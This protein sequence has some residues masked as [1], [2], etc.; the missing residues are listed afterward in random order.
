M[1]P[2][3][4]LLPLSLSAWAKDELKQADL[5]KLSDPSQ[6]EA[7]VARIAECDG[8]ERILT[9]FQFHPLPQTNGEPLHLL[10]VAYEFNFDHLRPAIR[11]Y[12]V[13]DPEELFGK[14]P[15][16]LVHT[17]LAPDLDLITDSG[18]FV[19]DAEGKEVRPFGGNNYISEG[20][21]YDF[22]KDGV[23]ERADSMNYSVKEAPKTTIQVFELESFELDSQVK[24]RVLFNWHPRSDDKANNWTFQC[25]DKDGDGLVEIGFGPSNNPDHHPFIFRWNPE[26]RY[27]SAGEIP[28]DAHIRILEPDEKLSDIAKAGGHSYPLI[29]E[30]EEKN[31]QPAAKPKP[32]PQ[33]NYAFKSL[34]GTDDATLANFFKG[35]GH[36]DHWDGPEGSFPSQLPEDFWKMEPKRAALALAEANRREDHRDAWKLAIDDRDGVTPPTSGW[37]VHNWGSSGCYSFSSHLFT[38]R[39]GVENPNLTVFGYNSIGVVGRNPWADQPAHNARHISLSPEEAR[40]LADTV[41]W[42]DR[43]RSWSPDDDDSGNFG[44]SSTADGSGDISLL[45]DKAPARELAVGSVWATRSISAGWDKHYDH[46]VMVNLAEFLIGSELPKHLGKRW[47]IA[48]EVGHHS[49]TTPTDERLK[50]RVDSDARQQLSDTLSEVLKLHSED[51]IPPRTLGSLVTTAGEEAL[52][53]LLP[54]LESLLASLPARSDEDEEFDQLERRFRHD[55]FGNPKADDPDDHEDAYQR[56]QDLQDK[57]KFLPAAVLRAP[58]EKTIKQLNLAENPAFLMKAVIDETPEAQWAL[59]RLRRADL[60]AWTN[61]LLDQFHAAGLEQ[62]G[63]IFGTIAAANPKAAETLLHSLTPIERQA[64]S[65]E[66]ARFQNRPES[67][68]TKDDLSALMTVVRDRKRDF[69]RRGQAM[70]L[71]ADSKLGDKTLKEF[72]NLVVA[73]VKDPQQGRHDMDTLDS[74]INALSKLPSKPDHL[75]LIVSLDELD[76]SEFNAAIQAI[77]HLV[78]D[79]SERE[80]LMTQLASK[81]ARD[82]K[83]MMNDLFLTCLAH[84]LREMKDATAG[85]ATASPIDREDDRARSYSNSDWSPEGRR[86]HMARE[87]VALWSETDPETLARMWA[88]FVA[89]HCRDFLGGQAPSSKSTVLR[90]LA[91]RH[92]AAVTPDQ[93]RKAIDAALKQ[94]EVSDY[95]TETV[96]WLQSLSEG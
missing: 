21:C 15:D 64:L 20:Y 13:E 85:F 1:K 51:P 39:F 50:P 81:H 60:D 14:E 9:Q 44:M 8:K 88:S 3:L 84:D 55:H 19:F 38:L 18:L 61:L 36:R 33:P 41:F 92:L 24:L 66:I 96:A 2:L 12:K 70:Q 94:I 83:G 74:A 72:T 69:I 54:T 7:E 37:L 76:Y 49:L 82:S 43:I 22:D 78:A 79:R 56:F 47:D 65:I 90:N 68:L 58:L 26:T 87:V 6:R 67:S 25:F 52:V 29:A 62:R 59:S 23:L 86:Y 32:A 16:A 75:E 95:N 30:A 89:S 17:I 4:L 46:D 28:K 5:S 10:A 34:K 71:L 42:L 57:R 45:P 27:Y 63:P 31:K 91:A 48:P 73:E 93:R 40:F 77:H 35:E 53:E 80:K 11:E